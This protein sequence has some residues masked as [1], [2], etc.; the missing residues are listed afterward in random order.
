MASI[1]ERNGRFLFRVRR[2]GF[3][4]VAKTFMKKADGVVWARRVEADMESG[5]WADPANNIPTLRAAIEE[6]RL[7]V[8]ARMKGAANYRYRFDE[9]AALPLADKL[10]TDVTPVDIAAWRD[11]QEARFKPGTV[12]RKL[13]Q[14][15]G[16]FTWCRK[17]RGW[18]ATNPVS[19]V[20]KPRVADGRARTL[21]PDEV[22]CLMAAART[23]KAAWLA[24]ALT[25][26][27]H[28]AMRRSELFGLTRRDI[29]FDSAI[30]RL[31]D[32]KNG[33][34][35]EVPLCPRSLAALRALDAAARA[36]ESDSQ[37]PFGAVGSLS[38]RFE[39]TVGRAR[40]EYMQRCAMLA[41]DPDPGFLGNLR[42]H[43]LRHHAV[44]HCAETGGLSLVELMQVSGHKSMSMLRRYA[45]L[46]ASKRGGAG[47]LHTAISGH[48]AT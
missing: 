6:Y 39:R 31:G 23:S 16:V 30:A 45:H 8:A 29:D 7:K 9:F 4:S 44:T 41:N 36:R 28:S 35:R 12:V 3:P 13:A 19:L 40:A 33:S 1:T 48:S 37:L 21:S 24:D 25:V 5:R 32:T 14:L 10:V 17:E 34:A 46:S 11:E 42:L 27:M 47:N 15:S 18:I 20:R 38:T 2:D 26:L 22:D 43:D